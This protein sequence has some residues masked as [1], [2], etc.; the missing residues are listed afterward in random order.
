MGHILEGPKDSNSH[1]T[2]KKIRSYKNC[3]ILLL[4]LSNYCIVLQAAT[5]SSL[6]HFFHA[7]TKLNF[8]PVCA[9]QNYFTHFRNP[10]WAICN[11][12]GFDCF[13]SH[14]VTHNPCPSPSYLR[15]HS[16]TASALARRSLRDMSSSQYR[17]EV[18]PPIVM[19]DERVSRAFASER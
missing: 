14:P 4:L 6:R 2:A 1:M 7:F 5:N 16:L 13:G 9:A 8:M 10:I 15:S 3:L 17:S 11:F 12:N 19:E 18:W